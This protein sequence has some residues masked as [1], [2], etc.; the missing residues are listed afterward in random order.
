MTNREMDVKEDIWKLLWHCDVKKD[1]DNNYDQEIVNS[2]LPDTI[3]RTD[4]FTDKYTRG[5]NLNTIR[6]PPDKEYLFNKVVTTQGGIDVYPNVFDNNNGINRVTVF[7]KIYKVKSFKIPETPEEFREIQEFMGLPFYLFI[8]TANHTEELIKN[9][10]TLT[11]AYTRATESD[12][13]G[14]MNRKTS[15]DDRYQSRLYYESITPGATQYLTYPD[16]TPQSSGLGLTHFYCKYP[17]T[18]IQEPNTLDQQEKGELNIKMYYTKDGQNIKVIEGA[19]IAT[20]RRQENKQK[21]GLNVNLST[22]DK[23]IVFISKH[24]GDIAQVLDKCRTIPLT[25]Y[26]NGLQRVFNS[27]KSCFVSIDI[28]AITKAFTI[29]IDSV[30]FYSNSLNKLCIFTV[31]EDPQRQM[32]YLQ[33]VYNNLQQELLA[34]E[35]PLLDEV[36]NYNAR[37]GEL[38]R[39]TLE[40]NR[41]VER[42]LSVVPIAATNQNYVECVKLGLRIAALCDYVPRAVIVQVDRNIIERIINLLREY[43]IPENIQDGIDYLK[44]RKQEL[45]HIRELFVIPSHLAA[46][47]IFNG[48]NLAVTEHEKKLMFQ[49]RQGGLLRLKTVDNGWTKINI[50]IN[51]MGRGFID[52]LFCSVGTKYNDRWGL[53]LISQAYT[54]IKT[55]NEDYAN[56]FIVKLRSVLEGGAADQRRW[57]DNG[58]RMIN[59]LPAA[60]AAGVE[61]ARAV[62]GKRKWPRKTSK[63]RKQSMRKMK[64]GSKEMAQEN[65]DIANANTIVGEGEEVNNLEVVKNGDFLECV[66][67]ELA[68]IEAVVN[69]Y[70]EIDKM[71]VKNIQGIT[72]LHERFFMKILNNPVGGGK[73]PRPEE[74]VP[75]EEEEGI[76]MEVPEVE[77][78]EELEAA[79]AAAANFYMT[80]P[81]L[82]NYEFELDQLKAYLEANY[83]ENEFVIEDIAKIKEIKH[84]LQVIFN[85]PDVEPEIEPYTKKVRTVGGSRKKGKKSKAKISRYTSQTRR[86]SRSKK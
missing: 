59:L 77:M 63:K 46:A 2:I 32:E 34:L 49:V 70:A 65:L 62:G 6:N 31:E 29:G 56:R 8:D 40:F 72:E 23:E 71:D 28:N 16:Y 60:G 5:T 52:T 11:Y 73:R 27:D 58:L 79:A 83:P 85:E 15:N 47:D 81:K 80:E 45:L 53:D 67:E 1:H 55:Y 39:R 74:E 43:R 82:K 78:A 25:N 26:Q 22:I 35:R 14:K 54:Q 75:E 12:A 33:G 51:P 41:I 76:V 19:N 10:E 37:I 86:A 24:H 9:I 42:D 50:N 64:G 57:L 66:K 21:N 4:F 18:L 7:G 3:L 13:A 30:W 68:D 48:D 36:D 20:G 69:F 17:V 61:P 38:S 44:A 84:T